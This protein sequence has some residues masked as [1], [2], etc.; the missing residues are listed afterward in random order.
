[1]EHPMKFWLPLVAVA[2][3]AWVG[4]ITA[5]Q[6]GKGKEVVLKG[7]ICCAKCELEL[8]KRCASVIVVKDSKG[9]DAIYYF[10]PKGNEKYHGE[11][12][13]DSRPGE[14]TGVVSEADGKKI[15]T[16]SK[17]TYDK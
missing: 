15:V 7:K 8:T 4:S 12:C 13:S 6:P 9:K 14:V 1:M 2:L 11:I 3:V 5:Q 16:V 10:D 17:L